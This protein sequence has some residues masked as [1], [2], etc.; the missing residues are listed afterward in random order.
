MTERRHHNTDGR[1][2]IQRGKTRTEVEHMARRIGATNTR[3]TVAQAREVV[4][5][6]F[7]TNWCDD[8]LTGPGAVIGKPPYD[9]RDIERILLAVHARVIKAF[10]ERKAFGGGETSPP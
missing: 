7:P 5:R 4:D 2:H 9:C 6:A 10:N 3:M 8:L 1:R